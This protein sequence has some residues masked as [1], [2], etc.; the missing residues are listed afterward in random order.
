MRAKIKSYCKSMGDRYVLGLLERVFLG[1]AWVKAS[2][3]LL[4]YVKRLE[5]ARA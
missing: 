5:A 3:K 4:G 1:E 2:E